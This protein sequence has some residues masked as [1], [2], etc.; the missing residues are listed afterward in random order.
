VASPWPMTAKVCYPSSRSHRRSVGRSHGPRDAP[1]RPRSRVRRTGLPHPGSRLLAS[2]VALWVRSRSSAW[3]SDPEPGSWL[4]P[5]RRAGVAGDRGIGQNPSHGPRVI[6]SIPLSLPGPRKPQQGPICWG[7]RFPLHAHQPGKPQREF[8]TRLSN[9]PIAIRALPVTELQA[10]D[11]EPEFAR[12]APAS[13]SPGDLAAPETG[14]ELTTRNGLDQVH[15]VAWRRP[16]APGPVPVLFH[17]C[18]KVF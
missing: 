9:S 15:Q 8:C 18:S 17:C 13:N 3:S 2:P 1:G 5:A 11:S 4:A 6:L 10:I 7:F 14:P 12:L 16:R